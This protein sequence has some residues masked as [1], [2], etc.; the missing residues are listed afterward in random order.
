[1]TK[2]GTVGTRGCADLEMW[3]LKDTQ[4][5]G[6]TC[7]NVELRS[8]ISGTGTWRLGRG[9]WNKGTRELGTQGL[10]EVIYK[11]Q[12]CQKLIFGLIV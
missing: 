6:K 7:K 1:M 2:S 12:S 4:G 8:Q 3:G 5:S 9:T 11:F 10:G